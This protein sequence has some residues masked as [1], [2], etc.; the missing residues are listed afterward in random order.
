MKTHHYFSQNATLKLRRLYQ[1]KAHPFLLAIV[2]ACSFCFPAQR[3]YADLYKCDGK[4]TNKPCDG[5][6]SKTIDTSKST[7]SRTGKTNY[8]KLEEQESEGDTSGKSE[9]NDAAQAAKVKRTIVSALKD[10]NRKCANYFDYSQIRNFERSCK[11]SS[12][13]QDDCYNL[14][15][16]KFSEILANVKDNS[17]RNKVFQSINRVDAARQ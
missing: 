7:V 8:K 1:I 5:T 15:E 6:S 17:C 3:A 14:W 13:S 11:S 12:T 16:S 10:S 4:W 2:F 9:N